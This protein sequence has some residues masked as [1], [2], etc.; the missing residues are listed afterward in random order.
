[1]LLHL[2]LPK[3]QL[4]LQHRP[5]KISSLYPLPSA[6]KAVVLGRGKV[7]GEGSTAAEEVEK[8]KATALPVG[9]EEEREK[10]K[11]GKAKEVKE[12]GKEEGGLLEPQERE[13]VG[14]TR[15]SG[16]VFSPKSGRK[17]E[18]REKEE[19]KVEVAA[20]VAAGAESLAQTRGRLRGAGSRVPPTPGARRTT[21][22]WHGT[23]S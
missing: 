13:G 15:P 18:I 7:V 20:A 16:P 9:R 23:Q 4:L 17:S 6:I 5:L 1:V 2:R 12:K 11:E 22:L 19:E 21:S 8:A 3:R 14:A 10:A